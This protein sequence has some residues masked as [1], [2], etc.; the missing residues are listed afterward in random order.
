VKISCFKFVM[1]WSCQGS[2]LAVMLSRAVVPESICELFFSSNVAVTWYCEALIGSSVWRENCFLVLLCC[3]CYMILWSFRVS[4]LLFDMKF[5]SANL[6][7][8]SVH[9]QTTAA[10]R[11]AAVM[12]LWFE[13]FIFYICSCNE[14][15]ILH[16][17]KL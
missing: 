8:W 15:F 1:F 12:Q 10:I 13:S 9:E 2:V 14:L 4:R 6:L 17:N 3:S 11:C 7:L 16:P 5:T